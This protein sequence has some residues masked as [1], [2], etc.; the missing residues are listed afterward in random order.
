MSIVSSA[1]VLGGFFEQNGVSTLTN[2]TT[3][4]APRRKA[5]QALDGK[6]TFDIRARMTALDGVAPGA[7]ALKTNTVV[8]ANVE[9]GGL[10]AI[11]TETLINRATT[12]GDVTNIEATINTL[13]TKTTF[14]ASP[15]ANLDG[16][17][18]G[19]R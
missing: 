18:L 5:A 1:T 14:G 8:E 6:G 2:M 7:T 12:A 10:R 13:S 11:T 9:L 3:R 16:N 17:P 15:P 4:G 19:T